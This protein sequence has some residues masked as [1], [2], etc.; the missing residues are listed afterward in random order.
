MIGINPSLSGTR[1]NIQTE[2]LNESPIIPY[3]F[4]PRTLFVVVRTIGVVT[5]LTTSA[6]RC[7]RSKRNASPSLSRDIPIHFIYCRNLTYEMTK[8]QHHMNVS[9]DKAQKS[10]KPKPKEKG[11]SQKTMW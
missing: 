4:A 5:T 10:P 3:G 8:G 9:N 2:F 11:M 1:R 7:K 6:V